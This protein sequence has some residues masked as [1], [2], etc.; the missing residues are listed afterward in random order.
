MVAASAPSAT[1]D[2]PAAHAQTTPARAKP[3]ILVIFGDDIGRTNLSWCW[4]GVMGYKTPHTDRIVREGAMFTDYHAENSRTARR[5][6]FIACDA[7]IE[8]QLL[9]EAVV[10]AR[11][12]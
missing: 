4:F 5:S 10:G 2:A 7:D 6:S 12:P 9:K 1:A 8:K 3:N 11:P